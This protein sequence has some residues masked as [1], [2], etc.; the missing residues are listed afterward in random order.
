MGLRAGVLEARC[1]GGRLNAAAGCWAFTQI[2]W[3]KSG[4]QDTTSSGLVDYAAFSQADTV[5]IA[6]FSGGLVVGLTRCVTI[7]EISHGTVPKFG[8]NWLTE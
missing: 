4:S 3:R 5:A 8:A 2:L 6:L 7:H 1:G